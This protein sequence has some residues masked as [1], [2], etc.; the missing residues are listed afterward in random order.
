M[1]ILETK[2]PHMLGT[3]CLFLFGSFFYFWWD[4]IWAASV[5]ATEVLATSKREK[6]IV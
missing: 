3:I 4:L 6:K 1:K 2:K 5:E